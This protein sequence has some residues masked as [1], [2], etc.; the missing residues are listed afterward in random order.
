M[1]Y[2]KSGEDIHDPYE[3][4]VYL[5]IIDSINY[6]AIFFSIA[7]YCF[8]LLRL[9]CGLRPDL[10]FK[11]RIII[12]VVL[13]VLTLI[14]FFIRLVFVMFYTLK[15]NKVQDAIGRLF[16]RV[17]DKDSGWFDFY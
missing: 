17:C 6:F 14:V 15:C 5:G 8:R 12:L 16:G 11:G 9:C 3:N 2:L 1:Y 10:P 7:I 4:D 13:V